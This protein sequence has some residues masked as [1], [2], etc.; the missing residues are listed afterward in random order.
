MRAR[1]LFAIASAGLLLL[2]GCAAVA[3]EVSTLDYRLELDPKAAPAM[4]PHGGVLRIMR[5]QAEAGADTRGI[6]YRSEP[7]QIRYYTKSRWADTPARMLATT[8]TAALEASGLF[9]AVVDD[10]RLSANYLLTTQ[11]HRLEQ[12]IAAQGEGWV[13]L[14]F[15]LQLIE[16]PQRKLLGSWLIDVKSPTTANNAAAAVAAANQALSEATGRAVRDIA[17]ALESSARPAANH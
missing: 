8:L 9:D 3:P 13:Q 1:K 7:H 2:S 17:A 12:L 10:N 16:L 11:L 6:A 4:P 15:R 5:P 14:Q